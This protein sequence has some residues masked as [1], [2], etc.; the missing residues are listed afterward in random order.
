MNVWAILFWA[1]AATVLY[2]YAGYPLLLGLAAAARGRPVRRGAIEPEVTVIVPVHNS[3]EEIRGKIENLLRLDYPPDRLHIIISSDGSTDATE[4]A[5]LAFEDRGVRLVRSERRE[6]KVAA[7]N[8]ALPEATGDVIVFTDAGIRLN[9][10]AI[11]EIVKPFHDPTVGCVSSEDE[12]PG[13]GEGLYVRYE[14]MIRRLEARVRTLVGVSGS[15][16]A[17][18]RSLVAPTD[19]RFTRDFLVPL[20][21]VAA[22]HRVVSEP[23]ARGRFLPVASPGR[24]FRR[25]TRTVMRGMD[26]LRR[27]RRLLDPRR[28]PF[29][30]WALLS[31]KV[32]RWLVPWAMIA[33]LAASFPLAGRPFFAVLLAAQLLFYGLAAA[34][35]FSAKV[36]RTLPG[37]AALFLLTTNAAVFVAWLLYLSGRR[38]VTWEPTKR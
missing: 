18:R 14:M 3:P 30:A 12:V 6:G 35:A 28:G 7:Q 36:G 32:I 16:Y 37:K 29:V 9:R 38:A 13:G 24:E 11:R 33:A 10:E 5:V 2:A 23:R 8:R 22:G 31:H 20:E 26:V 4:E 21:I 1:A 25:K 17:V 19:R 34:A 15:F 27:M